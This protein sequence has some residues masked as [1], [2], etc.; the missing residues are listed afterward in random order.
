VQFVN[1]TV[2]PAVEMMVVKRH[3]GLKVAQPFTDR[4]D[5]VVAALEGIRA[6][7]GGLTSHEAQRRLILRQIEECASLRGASAGACLDGVRSMAEGAAHEERLRVLTA[8][9]D[10][11][12]TVEA[13]GSLQGRKALVYVSNGLPM[14]AGLDLVL[15]VVP[16]TDMSRLRAALD[17]SRE[18]EALVKTSLR[19]GV[20]LY[21]VD[22]A[23][24]EV[25]A[26]V[27]AQSS[28]PTSYETD[29]EISGNVDS[30]I[31]YMAQATGG[32]AVVNTNSIAVEL[33][34][35]RDDI[36]SYYSIGFT[37]PA[38]QRDTPHRVEIRLPRHKDLAIRHRG[39]IYEKSAD[40]RAREMVMA[41]LMAGESD[42]PFD[43]EVIQGEAIRTSK[44]VIQIPL[45]I[46]VPIA[47]I[48]LSPNEEDRKYE[49]KLLVFVASKGKNE[50][51]S[52]IA[53]QEFEIAVRAED[54]ARA[55]Q[56]SFALEPSI[57]VASDDVSVSLAVADPSSG[58]V[59]YKSF[60]PRP[61]ARDGATDR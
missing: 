31:L 12:T 59:S 7:T 61:P 19:A 25:P 10:L 35:L 40:T 57:L 1:D 22:A 27:S 4:G 53:H 38:T 42:N 52:M 47:N 45:R 49:G 13:L 37:V 8:I 3:L 20:S 17:C 55:I 46:V 26:G 6:E 34:H 14:I 11:E 15:P 29:F 60:Q 50:R 58:F 2:G 18:F 36:F 56:Q 30:P 21:T 44:N 24:L 28:V 48:S 54:L 43:M 5:E 33:D 16:T 9:R 41:G 23:G 51:M 39:V 32:R